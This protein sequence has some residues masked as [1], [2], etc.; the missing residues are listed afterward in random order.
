V[1]DKQAFYAKPKVEIMSTN[2]LKKK[3]KTKIWIPAVTS[4]L[5]LVVLILGCYQK[6]KDSSNPYFV[7]QAEQKIT[8]SEKEL[9]KFGSSVKVIDGQAQSHYK[10][11]LHFQK[12]K[13]HKLAIKELKRAVQLNPL[14]AKAYNAMGVS[15]DNLRRYSLAIGCYQRALKLDPKLDYV[16]NNLGYSYLLKNELDAAIV[17]FQK[18][19]EI[20]DN[21]KRYRN[22]LGL[23][24]VM[25][26]QYDE[27][28][29]QF[30][31][32]ES[33]TRAK[34]KLARLLD[35]LGKEKPD[36]Y[37]AKDSNSGRTREK[38]EDKKQAVV[39]L[40]IE[41][42]TSESFL[43][44]DI[45]VQKVKN[46]EKEDI[47]ASSSDEK[48]FLNPAKDIAPLD[49]TETSTGYN[50]VASAKN[51]G[52]TDSKKAESLESI[53]KEGYHEL[54]TESKQFD[55]PA[56]CEFC[57][58]ETAESD[59]AAI[60]TNQFQIIT[61]ENQKP[62]DL[63]EKPAA[64]TKADIHEVKESSVSSDSVYYISA[65][66]L[67]PD[68]ASEKNV[69]T[70]SVKTKTSG[71]EDANRV[72]N[73][74]APKVIEVEES[75]YLDAKETAIVT[76]ARSKKTKTDFVETNQKVLKEKQPS[77]YAA[78]APT[79]TSTDKKIDQKRIQDTRSQRKEAFS[80]A[81]KETGLE[82]NFK[83]EDIIVEVEIEIANGN[84]V[85]GAAGR[86]GRYLK[87][88]GFKVAKVT[89]ANSFDHATTKI[90]YCNGDVKNVYKLL[91]KIPLL[92]DQRSIIEL[93]NMGSR[94]KIIIGSDLVK[95]DR[96]I[97][98]TI[99]RKHKS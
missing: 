60:G 50:R 88:R 54:Q 15:Y 47:K 49:E 28:Y 25:K 73:T 85:N 97:S 29:A 79:I 19:I 26:G 4:A 46:Q 90:F 76:P 41:D 14:F 40:K 67:V 64:K 30:K 21:N 11:A 84:G 31:I 95:H 62:P 71:Y 35:K 70:E 5:I 23:A 83:S 75:Y 39:R 78:A 57:E 44:A 24:Y 45:P 2:S 86:F 96:I 81:A 9:N 10:M 42:N 38:S 18:A 56:H 48:A 13:K 82:E 20:N 92:P 32:V 68:P 93:K 55:Q 61:A 72:Q 94:I 58:D 37:F 98:S 89:N 1:E 91:Q 3:P 80:L 51:R 52:V 74:V 12:R 65:V 16:H 27:A 66:E 99:Y 8:L 87:S 33:E 6:I 43:E 63:R 69:S 34:E 59:N 7:S 22:N 53:E 77:V 36:Q 17:A